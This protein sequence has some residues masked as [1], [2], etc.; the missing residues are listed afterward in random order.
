MAVAVLPSGLGRRGRLCGVGAKGGLLPLSLL[1]IACHLLIVCCPSPKATPYQ[2]EP[3]PRIMEQLSP[4]PAR[5]G[6][7]PARGGCTG[8]MDTRE[9][10]HPK[11]AG[12]LLA[13]CAAQLAGAALPRVPRDCPTGAA[14]PQQDGP[15]RDLPLGCCWD[16][17]GRGFPSPGNKCD[18]CLQGCG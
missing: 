16:G 14:L 1:P 7:H 5:S 6:H 10:L 9:G 4:A 12:S 3:C 2:A 11:R 13:S 18:L 15:I 17:A 8:A